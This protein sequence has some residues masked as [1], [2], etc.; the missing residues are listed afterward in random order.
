MRAVG[1]AIAFDDHKDEDTFPLFPFGPIV[2]YYK[3][4]KKMVDSLNN[5]AEKIIKDKAKSKELDHSQSLVGKLKQE[6]LIEP[7]ELNKHTD[8]ITQVVANYMQTD[9]SR[10][11]KT[12]PEDHM[13]DVGINTAWIVRQYSG[14]YNPA[15]IHTHCDMSCV[16]YLKLPSDIDKE[17][18]EDYKDHHP[19]N[20]HIEFLHGQP[21]NLLRHT[22]LVKPSVGDFFLFPSELTHMVYPFKSDG[23][24]R[25]F[26]MN[27]TVTSL[28][29]NK[30]F[31][32]VRKYA[33]NDLT[34]EW[35]TKP[36]SKIFKDTK[37]K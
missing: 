35:H 20:G 12:F 22:Y 32:P 25:S 28:P 15:H 27:I 14:E 8:T 21:G 33:T 34:Q 1:K 7:T 24:R 17:W 4:P 9:L 37:D 6:F 2:F 13:L 36:R 5:Y 31:N 29:K 10:H 3:L 23:E 26:S 19:C 18:E 11:S 16:G 30:A